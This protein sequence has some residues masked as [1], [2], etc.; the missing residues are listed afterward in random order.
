MCKCFVFSPSSEHFPLNFTRHLGALGAIMF[1][2]LKTLISTILII[3]LTVI[4]YN[5]CALVR[6]AIIIILRLMTGSVR[7]ASEDQNNSAVCC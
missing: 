2:F 1:R 7:G 6:K 3:L 4:K 5:S